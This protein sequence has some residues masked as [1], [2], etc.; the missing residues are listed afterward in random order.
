MKRKKRTIYEHIDIRRVWNQPTYEKRITHRD[1]KKKNTNWRT[2][3]NIPAD[4]TRNSH[5]DGGEENSMEERKLHAYAHT[6]TQV[7]EPT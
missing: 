7:H 1:T 6:K 5:A 2:K 3:N 4:E